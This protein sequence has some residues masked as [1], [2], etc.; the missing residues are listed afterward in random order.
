MTDTSLII[1]KELNTDGAVDRL[2]ECSQ[3]YLIGVRHHSAALAKCIVHLLEA[4]S[5]AVILLELPPEFQAWLPWLADPKTNAPVALAGCPK[6]STSR[7][8]FYP[9]ADFSPELVAIRWAFQNDVPVELIDLPIADR[10][11]DIEQSD[12]TSRGFLQPLLRNAE[13]QDTGQ[14][15]DRQVE[16]RAPHST[17][18]QIR[19][20]ALLFGWTLRWNQQS[21][22]AYDQRREAFMRSCLA[23]HEGINTVAVVGSFHA[24]ALLPD[25]I[26]WSPPEEEPQADSPASPDDD[27][28]IATALI[29]YSFD[30]LD[31]RSGY[32]A[33]VRDP[34]WHQAVLESRSIAQQQHAVA[35]FAVS[36][37]RH[38]R[39]AGHPMNAAEA[40][41]VVRIAKDLATVRG[42]KVAGRQ[43]LLEALQLCLS[44][45]Q[46]YGIG[47]AVAAAMQSV[48]VGNRFGSLPEN[49]PRCGLEPA[50]DELLKRYNL[51]AAD[52]IGQQ[53]RMRLDR[54]RKRLDRA[55]EI[56]FQQLNVCQ[57]PY[58]TAQAADP[59]VGRE[60]LTSVW[61]VEWTNV[62]A[63]TIALSA[64]KGVTLEQAARGTLTSQLPPDQ[65]DY[66]AVELATFE[67]AAECGF[68]D[69]VQLG[70]TWITGPFAQSASLSELVQAMTFLDRIQAGHIAGMPQESTSCPEEL[71]QVFPLST[72]AG[73]RPLLQA[74]IAL[75]DGCMGAEDD[76]AADGLLDLILW[77]QQQDDVHPID[78]GR[79]LYSIRQLQQGGSALMQGAATGALLILEQLDQ[80]DFHQQTSSWLD[81][82]V[83]IAGRQQLTHRLQ[84]MLMMIGSRLMSDFNDLH[85]IDERLQAYSDERFLQALPAAR[86]GFLKLPKHQKKILRQHM[87][88]RHGMDSNQTPASVRNQTFYNAVQQQTLFEA[89]QAAAKLLNELM[90]EMVLIQDFTSIPNDDTIASDT[91]VATNHSLSTADRWRLI[92]GDN[93]PEMS[94]AACRAAVA[95]D[96]LYGQTGRSEEE[97][98]SPLGGRSGQEQRF[99]G[100]REW[101]E[102]LCQLFPDDVREEVLGDSLLQGRNAAL[103]VLDHDQVRPSIE[104][105]EQVLS[106]RG[107]L[108]D[109]QTEMLRKLAKRI[110]EQL[111]KELATRMAPALTGLTTPRPTRRRT[112]R[113]DLKRTVLSN[114]HT[115]R[116]T[117]DGPRLAPEQFYFQ[118]PAK[119]SL[120]WHIIYVLDISGS[121]EPSVIYSALTAAIFAGLPAV[122]IS[123]LAFNTEVVDFSGTVNDPLQMLLEVNVGGGT[124][125]ARGLQAA[126]EKMSVPSR[127]IVLLI[128][129]FEEGISVPAVLAQVQALTDSGARALGLAALSDDGKPRYHTGIAQQVTACGMPVAA[130][131]P[132][133]LA[134]WVGEQIR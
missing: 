30:Q 21:V 46:V 127:T 126:R 68:H 29:P 108:P 14:L 24:A 115:A 38:M 26:L 45:G 56:I 18:E 40:Q 55:R 122:S 93:A 66:S 51:P 25:P 110:T 42:Y 2:Y 62:T 10:H 92:L 133:Q 117:P 91:T 71:C 1:P 78:A 99:P 57:I 44:Q 49:I 15:W 112:T 39:A 23:M 83:S 79:L 4:R 11:T 102:E 17:A 75:L 43:E 9:F 54:L 37:C 73:T 48:L 105:L 107:N 16:A 32:P 8:S 65:A 13:C 90:P 100:T 61:M 77:Y 121:M 67:T 36:I 98:G 94:P 116:M 5:P 86:K 60:N 7:L 41:E 19:R 101:N 76:A 84:A 22:S 97:A 69:L 81:A 53:K 120:D 52:T 64:S 129:D 34:M 96:E 6:D 82:A 27:S 87:K 33:G 103:A 63:A 50:I 104:L 12:S 3:P 124:S 131:S 125:I 123:F 72:D 20:A 113:L 130:L 31:E 118:Q 119:R 28:Q 88:D 89:D 70:F 109:Q 106:L 74:A 35:D 47:K 58:A 132:G 80:R 134:R 59:S 128:T 111:A 95:L 85:G 114:L